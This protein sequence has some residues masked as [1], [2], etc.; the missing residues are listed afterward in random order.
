MPL[1]S[2]VIPA[3]NSEEF[4]E[5]TLSMLVSQGLEDC[6][7]IIVNDG[8]TDQTELI[9]H[10]FAAKSE[11]IKLVSITNSGVSVA[12]NTGLHQATGKYVYFLDSDD[13]LTKGSVAFFKH[14]L[15]SGKNFQI[16]S[17]G[18]E[19]RRNGKTVKRY[20]SKKYNKASMDT[21][22]LQRSFFSKKLLCHICSC[23]YDRV[24]LME[25]SLAFTPNLRIGED[26]EF[27]IKSFSLSR[28]FYYESRICFIYQIRADS[29]MQGYKEYS[30]EQFN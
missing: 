6:E 23:I 18:Y 3:Y 21:I 15:V 13:T 11:N 27:L 12:R 17:F 24:F 9:G 20:V 19:S 30:M 22:I 25:N 10:S 28:S 4:I 14:V 7:V 5:N 1:L 29:V 16:F 2:I 8:S 26:V